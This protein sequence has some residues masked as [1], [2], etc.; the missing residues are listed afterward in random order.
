[1]TNDRVL[2]ILKGYARKTETHLSAYCDALKEDSGYSLFKT[3]CDAMSYSLMAGG[4]RIRPGLVFAFTELFGGTVEAACSYACALE[5]VH[6]ASLIHDDLPCMDND[7]LRRGKPTNHT[8]FGESCALLAGD[9][10]LIYAFEILPSPLL[11]HRQ[12]IAALKVLSHCTGPCGMC[13]G[14][15]IDLENEGKDISLEVLQ[16]LHA[17]KTGAL[18]KCACLL[19]CLAAGKQETD[20]EYDAASRYAAALGLAFQITDDILDVVGDEKK[21]GKSCGSDQKDHKN[22]Y[23]TLL[24]LERSKQLAADFANEAKKAVAPF[25]GSEFLCGLA[26]FTVS[27]DA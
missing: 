11:S 27:R 5:M 25:P 26:D 14:Q 9:S 15:Q 7:T 10:L 21:L 6:T 2:E 17:K 4:K 13:G 16:T 20:P 3:L 22:T 23:V 19:G 8:V 24:G 12:N 18:I 1:M